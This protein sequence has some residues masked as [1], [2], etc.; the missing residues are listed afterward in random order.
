M[1]PAT[2]RRL[3]ADPRALL[4]DQPTITLFDRGE[5][6]T[7][8]TVRVVQ[9]DGRF[10]CFVAEGSRLV[11]RLTLGGSAAFFGVV[12]DTAFEGALDVTVRGL[13]GTDEPPPWSLAG[14]GGVV[15]E[16]TIASAAPVP[17]DGTAR[18]IPRT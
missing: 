2:A 9:R 1:S 3:D 5:P 17:E 11:E 13:R 14:R 8:L 7:C 10:L 16:L 12:G 15:L 4:G 6:A 18:S